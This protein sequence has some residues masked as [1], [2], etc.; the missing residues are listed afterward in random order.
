M[1]NLPLGAIVHT[2]LDPPREAGEAAT[3]TVLDVVVESLSEGRGR[4]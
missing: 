2:A 3:A 4:A 1:I